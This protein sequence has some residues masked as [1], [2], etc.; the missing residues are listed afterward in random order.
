MNHQRFVCLF[1]ST[2]LVGDKISFK[3]LRYY[4]NGV[5]VW[6]SKMCSSHRAVIFQYSTFMCF[7]SN[8]QPFRMTQR[9]MFKQCYIYLLLPVNQL[10]GRRRITYFRWPRIKSLGYFSSFFIFLR[11]CIVIQMSKLNPY[12]AL[13]MDISNCL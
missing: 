12:S 13:L 7:K 8:H 2:P 11:W 1:R 6:L 10:T 4:S 9:C 3:Y 5:V